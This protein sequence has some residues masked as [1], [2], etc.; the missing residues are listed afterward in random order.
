LKKHRPETPA[1]RAHAVF[2]LLGLRHLCV[3][4]ENS[5]VRGIITR[6]DLDAA[7]GHGAWRRNK[8]APGPDTPPPSG[9]PL[10]ILRS[11]VPPNKITL[12]LAAPCCHDECA[13]Y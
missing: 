13:D 3:V 10:H 9:K 1:E 5:H 4:D 8:M 7:A 6:R 2:T 11:R 12:L